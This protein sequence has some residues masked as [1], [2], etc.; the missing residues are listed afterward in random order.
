MDICE[1]SVFL[2]KS[3]HLVCLPWR[4]AHV[5]QGY[6]HFVIG[7]ISTQTYGNLVVSQPKK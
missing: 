1:H 6:K 7:A 4:E 5:H 3:A 2:P